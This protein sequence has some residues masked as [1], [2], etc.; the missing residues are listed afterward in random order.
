L[1]LFKELKRR[2]VLRV[3]I[4]YAVLAWLVA[5]VAQMFLET[6][7]APDWVFKTLLVLLVLG[8]P[9]AIFFAWAFELTPEGLKREKDVDRSQPISARTARKL[10]RAIIIVLL[11]ALGYF[12]WDKYNARHVPPA[13]SSVRTEVAGS[14]VS[15]IQDGFPSLPS[16]KSIAV[17]PF[18]NMSNNEENEYF[19]DGLTETLLN[20]LAQVAELKVAARTSS[21]AFKGAPVDIREIGSK[22]GV[23]NVLEGS[24]QRS[25]KRVRITAQLIQTSNG[26]HLW[27][28]T[29][30]RDLDNIFAV[31]DEIA[32]QVAK[33]LT[34]SLLNAGSGKQGRDGGTSNTEAYDLYLQ[35]RKAFHVD[36][37][38]Q[39]NE[40]VRLMRRAIALDPDF[41]LAWAGMAEALRR[42]ATLAG[43][44]EVEYRDEYRD[45]AE[46]AA[47]LA[48][49][50][51]QVLSVLGEMHFNFSELGQ[52]KEVLERAIDLEPSNATAWSR[53]A[54]LHFGQGRYRDAVEAAKQAMSIDPLDF[55]LKAMS[56]YKFT[57]TGQLDKAEMLA[58]AAL[59]NNPKSTVGLQ[60]LGNIYWRTG[61]IADAYRVYHRLLKLN[62]DTLYVM[63]RLATSFVELEDWETAREILQEIE[64]TNPKYVGTWWN[65][66]SN[67]WFCYITNDM[68]C[69]RSAL[70]RG[71]SQ[72][73]S[74]RARIYFQTTLARFEEDWQRLLQEAMDGIESAEER[75]DMG[76]AAWYRQWAALA[77]DRLGRLE[78]R[79]EMIELNMS[80]YLAGQSRGSDAQYI[81]YLQS[82]LQALSGD[83]AR[84]VSNLQAAIDR[85][86]RDVPSIIYLG[87]F[88]AILNE[89]EVQALVERLRASNATELERLRAVV[90]ELGP[91]W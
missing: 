44:A 13:E 50:N 27:S 80:Y 45:A 64:A 68:D 89:P 86:Y 43:L 66:E 28:Q 56:T 6:F 82:F 38:R 3:A 19:A 70:Q 15:A 16:D 72:A 83:T 11:L 1:T 53:L 54:D 61:R 46:K 31:Q 55:D 32:A 23:S 41:A 34:G 42:Y 75:D 67:G 12:A 69:V 91:I 20:Q 8:F 39:V 35:G 4:G 30:D 14:P 85:G 52:A 26:Y 7:G 60:A 74:E 78:L 84:A 9:F 25:G 79:D 18:V 73:D 22:L 48:P 40:S 47:E 62:P 87:Y 90:D 57:Q 33:A 10:D 29:F 81:Y 58:Q 5:Q 63:N 59:E 24:V 51:S 65:G 37:E 17:L 49:D 77:A 88:D 71:I 76:N 2:N 36:T 21:F